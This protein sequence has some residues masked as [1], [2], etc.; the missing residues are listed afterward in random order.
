MDP[1][2][3]YFARF[4]DL[5]NASKKWDKSERFGELNDKT[6]GILLVGCKLKPLYTFGKQ[7][8][9]CPSSTLRVSQLIYKITNL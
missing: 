5:T 8:M 7:Y 2:D 3:S 6:L 1:K 4:G 9:Y